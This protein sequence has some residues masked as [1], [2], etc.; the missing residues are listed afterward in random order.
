MVAGVPE[1][2]THTI[3]LEFDVEPNT[4][5]VV[6]ARFSYDLC[7]KFLNLVYTDK[8]RRDWVQFV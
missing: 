2:T 1:F 8:M 5:P 6:S 7:P 3:T 4:Q